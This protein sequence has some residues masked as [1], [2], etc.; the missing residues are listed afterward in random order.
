VNNFDIFYT[1][2]DSFKF[3]VNNYFN[4]FLHLLYDCEYYNDFD[5]LCLDSLNET[6]AMFHIS[7]VTQD[8][9]ETSVDAVK[10]Y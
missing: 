10:T 2:C 7:H 6:A 4:Y 3:D 5:T 8:Y 9:T 1:I